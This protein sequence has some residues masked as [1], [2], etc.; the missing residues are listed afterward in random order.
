MNPDDDVA[1]VLAVLECADSFMVKEENK[2]DI[3][4]H[5]PVHACAEEEVT[6]GR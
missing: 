2:T 1:H 5:V 6:E 4:A 3:W